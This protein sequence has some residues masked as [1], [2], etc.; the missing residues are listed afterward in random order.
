MDFLFLCSLSHKSEF[1]KINILTDQS[2]I[3]TTSVYGGKF[4]ESTDML[5]RKQDSGKYVYNGVI[6]KVTPETKQR[7]GTMQYGL[8]KVMVMDENIV[9]I[10]AIEF[11]P[12]A[13][14][15]YINV[16][17]NLNNRWTGWKQIKAI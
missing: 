11:I 4:E 2:I 17:S 5:S 7:P 16:F 6:E 3:P 12:N 14:N 8:K 10:I 15:I 9:S 1:M 13:G